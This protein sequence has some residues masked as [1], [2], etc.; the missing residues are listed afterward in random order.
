MAIN[1]PID[2]A[3]Y[4]KLI[5][6][7]EELSLEMSVALIDTD[8]TATATLGVIYYNAAQIEKWCEEL[9]HATDRDLTNL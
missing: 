2:N 7:I 8:L 6:R 5:K 9:Q 4:N 3:Y 1:R